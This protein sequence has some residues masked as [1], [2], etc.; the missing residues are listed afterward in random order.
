MNPTPQDIQVIHEH[1]KGRDLDVITVQGGRLCVE[2]LIAVLQTCPDPR[3]FVVIHDGGG[4][5]IHC[6]IRMLN[7]VTPRN[8]CTVVLNF[9]PKGWS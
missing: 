5:Q 8:D 4:I 1:P 2:E 9:G 7:S 6:D 3:A